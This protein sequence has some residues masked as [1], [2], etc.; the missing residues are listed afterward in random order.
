MRQDSSLHPPPPLLAC[1]RMKTHRS[2]IGLDDETRCTTLKCCC[3]IVEDGGVATNQRR[4]AVISVV[5]GRAIP[6]Q[7]IFS[8]I[9][10]WIIFFIKLHLIFINCNITHLEVMVNME[11]SQSL[12]QYLIPTTKTIRLQF[13]WPLTH[14]R[15]KETLKDCKSKSWWKWKKM[16]RN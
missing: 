14:R 6:A 11:F 4:I 9:E 3:I 5:S 8:D 13:F 12:R 15:G 16:K 10:K 7:A 1:W 2:I